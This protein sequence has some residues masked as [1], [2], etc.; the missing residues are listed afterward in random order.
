MAPSGARALWMRPLRAL[1]MRPVK[2]KKNEVLAC[3]WQ[4]LHGTQVLLPALAYGVPHGN[5]QPARH[6]AQGG[7]PNPYTQ[8]GQSP[9]AAL[10]FTQCHVSFRSAP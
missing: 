9:A 5:V 2:K 8:S 6:H 4:V 1:W 7:A 10:L 3:V